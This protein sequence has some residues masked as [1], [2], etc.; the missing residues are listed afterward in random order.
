MKRNTIRYAWTG[1]LHEATPDWEACLLFRQLQ[2]AQVLNNILLPALLKEGS[3][4]GQGAEQRYL[5]RGKGK[6]F[7]TATSRDSSFS[8]SIFSSVTSASWMPAWPELPSPKLR[9]E[10][11]VESESAVESEQPV[12]RVEQS[13]APG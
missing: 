11:V 13:P 8:P 4:A 9:L 10:P 12:E 1:L 7:F 5:Q 2:A 3:E 6:S